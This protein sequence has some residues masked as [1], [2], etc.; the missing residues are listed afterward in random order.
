MHAQ[1]LTTIVHFTAI[2]LSDDE[3][4]LL[5]FFLSFRSNKNWHKQDSCLLKYLFRVTVLKNSSKKYFHT[6]RAFVVRIKPSIYVHFKLL[7]AITWFLITALLPSTYTE[8]I[9]ELA[10][11]TRFWFLSHEFYSSFK[12]IFLLQIRRQNNENDLI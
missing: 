10:V 4:F 6:A 1:I 11:W 3:F 2:S 9:P 7:L 5:R 8:W 12:S